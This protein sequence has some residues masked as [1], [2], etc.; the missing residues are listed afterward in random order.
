MEPKS[1]PRVL[2]PRGS[3]N[4]EVFSVKLTFN[5]AAWGISLSCQ[6]SYATLLTRVFIT[7]KPFAQPFYE[8]HQQ[9][10]HNCN[11]IQT[12]NKN[13]ECGAYLSRY[14]CYRSFDRLMFKP[15][16]RCADI[17]SFMHGIRVTE[18]IEKRL[19]WEYLSIILDTDRVLY[20]SQ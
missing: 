2:E 10:E 9:N 4:G 6:A 7:L 8:T 12:K 11:F 5:P 15:L 18:S 14:K 17:F 1:F 13:M 16:T 3:E 20:A 19:M